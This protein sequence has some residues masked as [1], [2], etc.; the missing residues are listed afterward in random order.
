MPVSSVPGRISATMNPNSA[1]AAASFSRLSPS[2]NRDS[3]CGVPISRNSP[4]TTDGS[5]VATTA[6][7]SRQTTNGCATN[8]NNAAPIT[9]VE[10]NTATMASVKIGTQS[11]IMRRKSSDSATS[12]SSVGRKTY[13]NICELIGSVRIEIANGFSASVRSVRK[14]QPA[15]PPM[16]IPTI[17]RNT[18]NGRRSRD[19]KGWPMPIMTNSPARMLRKAIRFIGQTSIIQGSKG[20]VNAQE[21]NGDKSPKF[22]ER[23]MG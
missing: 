5:V 4:T 14:N 9:S 10:T 15:E 18:E 6:P 3:R 17:A 20:G 1:M 23:R 16:M 12:N 2:I 7:T 21:Q 19:A 11:S 22:L 8:G 13:R